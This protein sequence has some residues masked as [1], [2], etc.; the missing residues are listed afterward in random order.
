MYASIH[1]DSQKF[2]GNYFEF[3]DLQDKRHAKL[4]KTRKEFKF[5][6][7]YGTEVFVD[8]VRAR[9][10]RAVMRN[11]WDCLFMGLESNKVAWGVVSTLK[12]LE[13]SLS[14]VTSDT[15]GEKR[16]HAFVST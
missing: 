7:T 4:I 13:R 15:R 2:G 6:R 12:S 14:S 9:T 5:V 10:V 1:G 11:T 8:L 3:P 16:S